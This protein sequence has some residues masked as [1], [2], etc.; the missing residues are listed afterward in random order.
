MSDAVPVYVRC[1]D[2]AL[3]KDPLLVLPEGFAH[4]VGV[5]HGLAEIV[6]WITDASAPPAYPE[7]LAARLLGRCFF[8]KDHR[9]A[10][11]V[12]PYTKPFEYRP[13]RIFAAKLVERIPRPTSHSGLQRYAGRCEPGARVFELP[14]SPNDSKRIQLK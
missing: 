7:A 11:R 12:V 8:L 14:K 3:Y 1:C 4:F 13:A 10:E 6:E 2:G 5:D 9:E